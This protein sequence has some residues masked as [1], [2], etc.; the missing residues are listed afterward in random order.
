RRRLLEPFRPA[1]ARIDSGQIPLAPEGVPAEQLG[2]ESYQKIMAAPLYQPSWEFIRRLN[3][4]QVQVML[5]IW[6]APGAFTDDG[7]RRGVLLP[8]YFDKYVEYC[9]S[10]V[11]YLVRKQGLSIW[12]ITIAN[13]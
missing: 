12:A 5:G 2:P 11:D 1:V 7:T 4:Q 10:I 6:G 9:T 8:E 3:R 13:E